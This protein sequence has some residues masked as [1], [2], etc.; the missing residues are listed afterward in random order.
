MEI[1]AALILIVVATLAIGGFV[2]GAREAGA[3]QRARWRAVADELD[4][5]TRT[6]RFGP[7]GTAGVD[8]TIEGLRVSVTRPSPASIMSGASG[9]RIVYSIR[10]SP[11][12]APVGI[13]MAYAHNIEGY[14]QRGLPVRPDSLEGLRLVGGDMHAFADW[15]TP[16]RGA[17]VETLLSDGT[18][19]RSPERTI[20][21]REDRLSLALPWRAR[22]ADEIVTTTKRLIDVARVLREGGVPAAEL[23]RG[24]TRS[25]LD[26]AEPPQDAVTAHVEAPPT[27]S[28]PAAAP[29]P[30]L[31]VD[32][33]RPLR[34]APAAEPSPPAP[35]PITPTA[36]T[37]LPIDQAVA[38]LLD[39]SLMGHEATARFEKHH[40]GRV[41]EWTGT[42]TATR[43]FTS[44]RDFSSPGVRAT[45]LVYRIDDSPLVTN[46]VQAIVHLPADT[47][48]GNDRAIRFRGH[49]HR[50]DRTMR[51]FSVA[52]ATLLPGS[53]TEDGAS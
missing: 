33:T 5:T 44:D 9:D 39:R 47:T 14:Q 26:F 28:A 23:G 42:V 41:V 21:V 24:P 3:A 15:F 20:D 1:L 29:S 50:V 27:A 43:S 19:Q 13:R 32:I 46:Q 51:T 49:L 4:M 10:W 40:R 36:D 52:D 18:G 11:R 48:I 22:T 25:P 38:E 6:P 8:G 12:T 30:P 45:V 35:A 31:A 7:L 17:A 2:V 53:S 37:E 34:D 16:E